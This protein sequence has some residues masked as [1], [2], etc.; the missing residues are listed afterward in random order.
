MKILTHPDPFL[1][2]KSEKV[3]EFSQ[4][5]KKTVSDMIDAMYLYKGCGLASTQVGV[6]YCILVYDV[7]TEKNNPIEMVNAEIIKSSGVKDEI[8]EGCLSFPGVTRNIMRS[9]KIRVKWQS[10][11]GNIYKMDFFGVEARVI[12]HEIDHTNG[13]LFIDYINVEWK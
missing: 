7:S 13:I 9:R 6:N 5:L 4:E 12:Q 11:E 8:E 2:K 3:N 1:V 10:V